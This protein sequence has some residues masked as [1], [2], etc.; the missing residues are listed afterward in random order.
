MKLII[1]TKLIIKIRFK[2]QL[3]IDCLRARHSKQTKATTY[4][5]VA[6]NTLFADLGPEYTRG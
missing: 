5:R 3:K 4:R 6:T 2:M 1:K